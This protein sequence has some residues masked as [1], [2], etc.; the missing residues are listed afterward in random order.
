MSEGSSKPDLVEELIAEDK[1][2]YHRYYRLDKRIF[3]CLLENVGSAIRKQDTYM[4][5]T[6]S[7]DERLAVT[8]PPAG[9]L[10]HQ[11]KLLQLRP[12]FSLFQ[13]LG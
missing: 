11:S 1:P 9:P 7:A 3:K 13:I 2:M 4:R 5:K 8:F 10:F 12:P 6:I